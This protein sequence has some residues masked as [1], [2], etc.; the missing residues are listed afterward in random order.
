VNK[1]DFSLNEVEFFA[2]F[3]MVPVFIMI[4]MHYN[5]YSIL[6]MI[7]V[8]IIGMGSWTLYEYLMHRFLFHMHPWFMEQHDDH[9]KKPKAFIGNKPWMTAVATLII[10]GVFFLLFG[11]NFSSAYTSG[12]LLGYLIYSGIHVNLHHGDHRTYH[13]PLARLFRHHAAHHRGGKTN[14]GVSVDWW[15]RIFGTYTPT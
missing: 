10:W 1:S 12:I 2:D 7:A 15:D 13:R 14:F 6:G 4:M 11:E 9:H 8:L 5:G 3:F